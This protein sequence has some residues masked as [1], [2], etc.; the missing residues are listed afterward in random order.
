MDDRELALL[1]LALLVSDG[2]PVNWEQAG[3]GVE[4]TS[5]ELLRALE[6]IAGIQQA[7]WSW[8]N[9]T[10]PGVRR[11]A[12]GREGK[13]GGFVPGALVAG[14][15]RIEGEIGTGGF[16]RVYRAIDE[17]LGRPVALKTLFVPDAEEV[18]G[19]RA[20]R[21]LSEARTLAKL[22]H[23]HI[24]PV[25][26]AGV[27]T[28]TPWL[29]MK[30]VEGRNLAAVLGDRG[31]F[32]L[33]RALRVLSQV[34]QALRH[35]HERGIV[36]RDVKPA[37]VLL[38][39]EPDGAESVWL[40]DFGVARLLD[41]KVV[42]FETALVGTPFYM[43][44]EQV[45]GNPTDARTDIFSL[46]CLG[47]E[48]VS[49]ERL[50]KGESLAEVFHSIVR[51]I[52]DLEEV[53]IRT[54]IVYAG[55]MSRCLAKSSEDRWPTV[56]EFER[57]LAGLEGWTQPAQ[58]QPGSGRSWIRLWRRKRDNWDE[59]SPLRVHGLRKA[60]GFGRPVLDNLDLEIPRGAV[61]ALLGRNGSGK[62]T[63][64]RTCLGICH[65]DAGQVRIFGRDPAVERPA[66]MAR[67]GWV[68]D[69]LMADERMRVG[70]L[71]RFVSSFYP[72]WDNA[73]CHRLLA[74]YDLPLDKRIRALS[75]GMKT[76][77]SLVM[78]L[79][80]RPDF[81]LMDD[82]AL[83]LDAVVLDE[84][85]ETLEEAVKEDGTTVLIASHNYEEVERIAT[86]VGI[87]KDSRLTL[88]ESLRR[89]KERVYQVDLTFREAAPDLRG[90]QGLR[91]LKASGRCV[92]G[93]LSESQNRTL[94]W[95][96]ALTPQRLDLRELSLRELFSHL[97]R[98]PE[99]T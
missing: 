96:K 89:L 67:T 49:G 64:I 15:Y 90:V 20:A 30:L 44:P 6:A 59:L 92:T 60:Y 26:D 17:V 91:V 97:L 25:Y 40:T 4:D 54:G 18:A 61:Y 28:G 46:G 68:P 12:A 75:R 9:T 21:F 8:Q 70:Q 56:D 77:I 16:G 51:G 69:T 85:V 50:W 80:H 82:P 43:A 62:S 48:L 87:L 2:K 83:G 98:G 74:R 78:A 5:R 94:E 73:Q 3:R 47:C 93:I 65:R 99:Q 71:I 13:V 27:E 10:G 88:S 86:H 79:A 57:A 72:R 34:A 45:A 55:I 36:H 63:L 66:I 33:E 14:R 41:E 52:P 19:E 31:P 42:A 76:K 24:V 39:S 32:A 58:P 23:K 7:H 22:E 11:P 1:D 37:N 95:L 84:L 81:L 29:T 38:G 53:K 35:A